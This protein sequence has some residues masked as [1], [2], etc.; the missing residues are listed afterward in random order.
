MVSG[1][2]CLSGVVMGVS[3]NVLLLLNYSVWCGLFG[4]IV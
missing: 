1:V 3:L 4:L 2:S